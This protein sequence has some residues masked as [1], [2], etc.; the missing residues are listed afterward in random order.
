[1]PISLGGKL[2]EHG[3]GMAEIHFYN[4]SFKNVHK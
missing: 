2:D 1:M 3:Q 4:I